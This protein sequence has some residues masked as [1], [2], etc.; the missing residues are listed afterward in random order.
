MLVT[1]QKTYPD[2]TAQI[3]T[4]R[5]L[6]PFVLTTFTSNL[7]STVDTQ[8]KTSTYVPASSKVSPFVNVLNSTLWESKFYSKKHFLEPPRG[9]SVPPV[10]KHI[11]SFHHSTMPHLPPRSHCIYHPQ[12]TQQDHTTTASSASTTCPPTV[13][14]AVLFAANQWPLSKSP[15]NPCVLRAN[16]L[17]PLPI[18]FI[19]NV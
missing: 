4:I 12:Q 16:L 8:Q 14:Q 2:F 9:T 13:P 7:A 3:R 11:V 15:T 19:P 1:E 6:S 17:L 18:V 5:T 10:A